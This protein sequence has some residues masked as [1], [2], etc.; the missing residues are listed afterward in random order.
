MPL[1]FSIARSALLLSAAPFLSPGALGADV[2]VTKSRSDAVAVVVCP[3]NTAQ[4][5]LRAAG[6]AACKDRTVCNAW[7]WE[8]AAKAP[9]QAP[10]VDKDLPKATAG[11]ARA[12][13]IHDGQQLMELRRVR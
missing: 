11:A 4:A 12:V 1:Q 9:A 8:D 10:A 2:C 7:I 6:M 5:E 13:W 3:P